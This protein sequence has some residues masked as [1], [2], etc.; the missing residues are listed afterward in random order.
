MFFLQKKKKQKQVQILTPYFAPGFNTAPCA[1][2]TPPQAQM[3]CKPIAKLK[4]VCP[5]FQSLHPSP[6]LPTNIHTVTP[7]KYR[8]YIG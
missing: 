7:E 8:I 3:H 4:H 6:S 1:Q 2:D 5:Q